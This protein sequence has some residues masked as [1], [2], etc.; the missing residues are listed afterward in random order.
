MLRLLT[1]LLVP[2]LLGAA[3]FA[4]FRAVERDQRYVELVREGDDLLAKDLSV[5][6]SRSYG[7]AIALKPSEPLAYVK[8]ADAEARQGNRLRAIAD[9]QKAGELSE[10]VLLVSSRLAELYYENGEFDESARH[11]R[12]ILDVVPDSPEILYRLGLT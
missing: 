6:A 11:Y 9:V 1:I 8:R 12:K 2:P 4:A 7:T 10:D 3:A 5:E